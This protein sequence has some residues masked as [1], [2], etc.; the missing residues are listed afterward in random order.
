MYHS[1]R[2]RMWWFWVL[3]TCAVATLHNIAQAQWHRQHCWLDCL[4]NKL[5]VQ[6]LQKLSKFWPFKGNP[7]VTVGFHP[8]WTSYV[9][10]ASCHDVKI[11]N[12][13]FINSMTAIN[14]WTLSFPGSHRYNISAILDSSLRCFRMIYSNVMNQNLKTEFQSFARQMRMLRKCPYQITC[15]TTHLYVKIKTY[16]TSNKNI[17]KYLIINNY[18]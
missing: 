12:R 15:T 10:S 9:E 8:Q 1:S 5:F 17:W 13:G 18:P 14:Q 4:L 2:R 3:V 16:I 11:V 6:E 7:P